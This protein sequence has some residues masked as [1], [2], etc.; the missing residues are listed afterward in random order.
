M[1]AVLVGA[2]NLGKRSLKMRQ[3]KVSCNRQLYS[4]HQTVY[5]LRVKESHQSEGYNHKDKLHMAKICFFL[6][7]RMTTAEASSLASPRRSTKT[8]SKNK[9]MFLRKL[10]SQ[11][12]CLASVEFLT[13]TQ[14]SPC[15]TPF[16]DCILIELNAGTT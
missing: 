5:T 16:L 7:S 11:G 13:D 4:E 8:H 10:S 2:V 14:N 6:E 15:T 3:T 9:S 1:F 12:S